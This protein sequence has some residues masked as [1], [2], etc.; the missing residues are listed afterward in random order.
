MK[1]ILEMKRIHD[2]MLIKRKSKLLNKEDTKKSLIDNT[3]F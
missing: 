1:E 3:L 2:K